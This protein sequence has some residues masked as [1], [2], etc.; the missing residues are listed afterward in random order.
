MIEAHQDILDRIVAGD[1]EGA[2]RAMEVNLHQAQSG[3]AADKSS[4][5]SE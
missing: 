5:A 2:A 4:E 3:L 1:S